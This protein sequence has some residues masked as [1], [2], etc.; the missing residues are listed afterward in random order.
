MKDS[1]EITFLNKAREEKS[2]DFAVLTK[3]QGVCHSGFIALW[4][5]LACTCL[6]HSLLANGQVCWIYPSKHPFGGIA[7]LKP[8][9]V[10]LQELFQFSGF[11]VG[12]EEKIRGR[13]GGV[14]VGGD[15]TDE[16]CLQTG[17]GLAPRYTKVSREHDYRFSW[18]CMYNPPTT[19]TTLPRILANCWASSPLDDTTNS[20][21]FPCYHQELC[22]R[23]RK[24][25]H[26]DKVMS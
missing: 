20:P 13:G 16:L 1:T 22:P 12:S 17:D 7:Q 18:G 26:R 5:L 24:D 8:R 2:V 21:H 14:C 11:S 23:G 10:F 6:R 25:Q 4:K 3:H 9:V 15:H 19:T